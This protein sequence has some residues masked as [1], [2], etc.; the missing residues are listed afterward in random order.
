MPPNL[1]PSQPATR[2]PI[3]PTPVTQKQPPSRALVAAIKKP[4]TSNTSTAD[5]SHQPTTSSEDWC[6]PLLAKSRCNDSTA[7]RQRASPL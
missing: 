7:N 5:F 3:N 6:M 2:H 1:A 4:Y